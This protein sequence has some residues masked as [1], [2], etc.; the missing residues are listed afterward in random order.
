VGDPTLLVTDD[1]TGGVSII[2]LETA[3]AW[4][5][6]RATPPSSTPDISGDGTA[7]ILRDATLDSTAVA[8]WQLDL[9]TSPAATAAWLDALTNATFDPRTGMLGWPP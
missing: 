4:K 5:I 8:L 7:V 3:A 1:N 9:P 6:A 2:D